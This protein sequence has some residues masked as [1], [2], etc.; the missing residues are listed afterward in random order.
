MGKAKQSKI[1]KKKERVHKDPAE[2]KIPIKFLFNHLNSPISIFDGRKRKFIYVNPQ[3]IQL[4]GLT[5]EEL[6]AIT[7]DEFLSRIHAD[8]LLVV[9]N[10]VMKHIWEACTKYIF[11]NKQQLTFTLNY[12]FRKKEGEY[13]HVMVQNTVLEWDE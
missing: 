10:D 8:D 12:R 1:K 9:F 13:I 11:E 3:F 4:T 7:L 2:K 6:Y 5:A